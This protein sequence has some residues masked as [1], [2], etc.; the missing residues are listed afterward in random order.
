MTLPAPVH[1]SSPDMDIFRDRLLLLATRHGKERILAPILEPG[2]G[3]RCTVVPGLDT[4]RLGTFTGEVERTLAP[5][6]A[7]REKCRMAMDLT[8]HDLAVASEGSFGPHPSIPFV[9]ADEEW[10]LLVD[11]RQGL[12]VAV[13]VCSLHTN[14]SATL[15]ASEAELRDFAAAASFP[16]HALILRPSPTEAAGI[17]KGITR[18]QDLAE[19]FRSLRDAYGTVHVETD[20]R[21]MYNPTRMEVIAQTGR[22]LV[23]RCLSVCPVCGRPGFAVRDL[24]TGLPC[25][26]CGAPT[27][28]VLARILACEGCGHRREEMYPDGITREDPGRCDVCNP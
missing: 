13:R 23:D 4:D 6:E 16:S 20:M 8:G 25:A 7:A 1:P 17:V 5:L 26:G 18:M 24:R 9:P 28:G 21:A 3:V 14:F 19:G 2:L 11:R 22:K 12:E 10:L 15:V 27:R